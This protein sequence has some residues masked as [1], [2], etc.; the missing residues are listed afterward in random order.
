MSS[1]IIC[2][3][4][5]E[6]WWLDAVCGESNWNYC[7][8]YQG[9][10]LVG[11]MPYYTKKIWGFKIIVHPVLTPVL[12]PWVSDSKK[13]P[14][15]H[16]IASRNRKIINKLIEQLPKSDYFCCNF[17]VEITDWMPFYYKKYSQET[18]YTYRLKNIK[19]IEQTWNGFDSE[20]RNSIRKAINKGI[21]ALESDDIELFIGLQKK[22]FLRQEIK[23]PYN[24]DIIRKIDAA[25]CKNNSRK[26]II[27]YDV[28]G[29]PICG[30]YVVYNSYSAYYLMGGGDPALRGSGAGPLAIWKS[31][32]IVKEYTNLYD[33]EGSMNY[34]I[35][36]YFMGFGAVQTP[37]FRVTKN[38]SKVL[39]LILW[40]RSLIND[41]QHIN[42][43]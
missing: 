20:C 35:E 4:F 1:D 7:N 23:F 17:S 21:V 26:I 32:N 8:V 11:R 19:N 6:P 29:E 22:T 33:F 30:V 31:I 2:P 27:S 10:E 9:T 34:N 13:K 25:C 24:M 28:D 43:R 15:L 5:H 37:L 40:L 18:H 3:I 41:Y 38:H 39:S 42:S 36:K 16:V 12:G 14:K